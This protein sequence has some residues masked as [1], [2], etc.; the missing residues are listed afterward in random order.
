MR[1][2][3]FRPTTPTEV[4]LKNYVELEQTRL[5]EDHRTR[6]QTIRQAYVLGLATLGVSVMFALIGL[7]LV[8]LGGIEAPSTISLGEYTVETASIGVVGL[9]IGGATLAIVLPAILKVMNAAARQD[10]DPIDTG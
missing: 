4:Q 8:V 9:L 5:V 6:R 10:R 2:N 3:L 7:A 1:L